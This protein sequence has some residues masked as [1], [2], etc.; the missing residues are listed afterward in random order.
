MPIT[1]TNR[2]GSAVQSVQRSVST[3][4]R[5][6]SLWFFGDYAYAVLPIGVLA[7]VT[8]F[9]GERFDDFF[10]LPEWSFATIVLF[11]LS[12]RTIIRVKVH[13]QRVP[14]SSRLDS[15]IQIFVLTIVAAVLTLSLIILLQ[16]GIIPRTAA[17]A[18]QYVQLVLFLSASV[19]TLFA[20]E[21]ESKP[22]IE[23]AKVP[24]EASDTWLVQRAMLHTRQACSLLALVGTAVDRVGHHAIEAEP[25]TDRSWLV[26]LADLRTRLGEAASLAND[27]VQRIA[28]LD[29]SGN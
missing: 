9:L 6:L 15:G 25:S 5:I 3:W 23:E 28:K 20:A 12:I 13:L 24:V 4:L 21:A 1:Q 10:L 26:H 27:A 16:K 8:F 7:L 14:K 2:F 29:K 17:P 18:L 11:G 19:T 22:L